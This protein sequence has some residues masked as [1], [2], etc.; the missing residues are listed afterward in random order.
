MTVVK[1][2]VSR[3]TR[4]KAPFSVLVSGFS[5]KTQGFPTTKE[6][7]PSCIF[8]GPI[9]T[10]HQENL[11]AIYHQAWDAYCSGEPLIVDDMFDRVQ[12]KLRWYGSKSVVKYPRCS[13]SRHSTYAD[14]EV[15]LFRIIYSNCLHIIV[16]LFLCSVQC[17]IYVVLQL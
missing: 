16:V 6:E 1:L 9:E 17:F 5:V 12:F 2:P 3:A 15:I 8:V 11:E 10:A 7:G 4:T 13:I 14:A